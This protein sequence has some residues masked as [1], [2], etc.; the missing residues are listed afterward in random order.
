MTTIERLVFTHTADGIRLEG[1]RFAPAGEESSPR[2]AVV[3]I[4]GMA[5]GFAAQPFVEIGR[6][7]AARGHRFFTVNTRGHEFGAMLRRANGEKVL[8]GGGWERY[9]ETP[10]DLQAW[11][12]FAEADGAAAVV[13][14]G[15]SL[16]GLKIL[17]HQAGRQ[18]PRIRAMILASPG[19]Y[20]SRVYTRPEVVE[21]AA[22]LVA[23]G[24]GRDLLPW[25]ISPYH[26]GS[27]SA[28]TYLNRVQTNI[29]AIGVDTPN[30]ALAQ[31][32]V[33]ILAFF[34]TEEPQVG[35]AAELDLIRQKAVRAPRVDT[36]LFDGA[37]HDYDGYELPIATAIAD[38]LETLKGG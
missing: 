38:W 10:L 8:G 5:A 12:D 14:A 30:P 15:H 16:G 1:A 35:A 27:I 19:V 11:I 3:W 25:G 18:D 28:L 23:E 33:P 13:L 22:Q 26:A 17:F 37:D 36:H 21:L 34:G 20:A 32:T 7:I 31:I 6:L 9:D 29:D 2:L 24:K 4:H